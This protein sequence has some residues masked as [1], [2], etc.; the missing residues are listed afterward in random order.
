MKEVERTFSAS[1]VYFSRSTLTRKKLT[2]ELIVILAILK[3][4]IILQIIGTTI[5]LVPLDKCEYSI[6]HMQIIT[7]LNDGTRR[8]TELSSSFDTP[9]YCFK[10]SIHRLH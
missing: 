4:T 3:I 2:L 8:I 10:D 6:A 7:I 9:T 5:I 1:L